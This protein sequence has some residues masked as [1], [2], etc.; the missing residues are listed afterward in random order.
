MFRIKVLE[1]KKELKLS[2]TIDKSGER[3][4]KMFGEIAPR[5]DMMNHVLSGGTDYYWRRYSIKK[6]APKNDAP[7]LD[8]CTGTGDLAFGWWK[9]GK[10]KIPVVGADFTHEMLVLANEKLKKSLGKF[11]KEPDSKPVFLEADAQALPFEDNQFQIVSVAFGLRNIQ[12]TSLGLREMVRVC[13]P[14]GRVAVLEFSVPGNRILKSGYLWY[15]KNILP[16]IGQLFA[17]NTQSA[18]EYLPSTVAEFPY[19]KEL[20]NIMEENGLESVTHHPLTFGVAT[21]Y[22]GH[23]PE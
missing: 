9:K 15:F 22:I 21:L 16:R 12:D 7:I 23:K 11:S 5:Y 6:C 18:Y 20:A 17:R 4:K 14:G 2:E 10:Y 13:Q 19:G 1:E 3:V 8:L